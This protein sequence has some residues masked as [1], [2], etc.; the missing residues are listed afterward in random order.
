MNQLRKMKKLASLA[1]FSL[2]LMQLQLFAAPMAMAQVTTGNLQGIVADPTGAVVSGATVRITNVDTGRTVETT[3]NDEGFFRV[4]N[5][6]PGDNY[7]IEVTA[8]GFSVRT[9][10]R[11]AV[12][13]GVEN[14]ANVQVS[15]AQ[16]ADETVDVSAGSQIIE[17]AQSQL[18]ANYTPEQLTQLPY[19]G[20][21]DNLA[22]LTPGVVRPGDTD[23]ANGTG[24]S[25][26]GNRGR[27]NNFQ[28]DGQ[29]NNDNSVAGP[30]LTITNNEAVGEFQVITNSF[31]AEFGRN[32]G[33]Q[34]NVITKPGTN[35]FHGTLFEYLQN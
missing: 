8:Q 11:V 27:S 22:L 4:T 9:L 2:V 35:N 29:D 7:R 24:I 21:I 15:A 3:T 12:R 34:I 6:I 26:N 30:S 31:S 13:L 5:L 33:A 32:S 20:S 23:F 16:A 28:I 18:S 1:V 19:V 10:E 25:A 14:N 17:S